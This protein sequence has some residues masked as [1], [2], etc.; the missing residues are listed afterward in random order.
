MCLAVPGKVIS[1][2]EGEPI[3]RTGRV[4]F[5]G[6]IREINLACVPEVKVDD[7]VL[8]HVGV[9]I[10]VVDP[11]EAERVF[12]YLKEIENLSNSEE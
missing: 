5:G 9:A 8:A 4:S 3:M 10:S 7:Y 11:K 1:I 2:N 12:Q 6:V